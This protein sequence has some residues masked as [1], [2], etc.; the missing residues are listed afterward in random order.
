MLRFSFEV[1]GLVQGVCFRAE[2]VNQAKSLGLKGWVRNTSRNTV[3]GVVEGPN[4]SAQKMKHWL[5]HTGSP[6]SRIERCEFSNESEISQ[7]SF[8]SFQQR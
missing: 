4:D 6:Q 1:F 3:E 7:F 5:C 8:E 2:T